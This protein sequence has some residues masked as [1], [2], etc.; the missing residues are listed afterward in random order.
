MKTSLGMGLGGFVDINIFVMKILPIVYIFLCTC[1]LNTYYC[2]HVPLYTLSTVYILM[3]TRFLHTSFWSTY[4]PVH[5]SYCVHILLYIFPTY[6]LLEYIFPCTYFLL[7]T[8]SSVH[9]PIYFLLCTYSSVH[10][11]YILHTLYTFLCT[12]FLLCTYSSVHISYILHTLYTF[13]CTYF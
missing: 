3:C 8:H 2:V 7:C 4:S 1:F 9:I 13:L 10:T 12:Y 5:T 6:F 11:S